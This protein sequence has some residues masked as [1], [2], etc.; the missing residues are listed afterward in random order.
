MGQI[1]QNSQ[2]EA[3]LVPWQKTRKGP[4]FLHCGEHGWYSVRGKGGPEPQQAE[5]D[6]SEFLLR[7]R[8]QFGGI[9]SSILGHGHLLKLR[10]KSR[11]S[12]ASGEAAHPVMEGEEQLLWELCLRWLLPSA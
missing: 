8:E 2:G 11:D 6:Q 7:P 1:F 4:H 5:A 10:P 12:A 3:Q 9:F